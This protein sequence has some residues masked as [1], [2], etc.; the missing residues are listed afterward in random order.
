[1]QAREYRFGGYL[2]STKRSNLDLK[3]IHD[4][5]SLKSYWAQGRTMEAIKVSV[6]NSLCFGLFNAKGEQVGFARV[7]TDFVTFGWLCDVFIIETE[8]GKGLGKWLIKTVIDSPEL[9]SL[10]RIAL[11]TKDAQK[12]YQD[13]GGFT[14][15]REPEKWMER[16]R[17]KPKS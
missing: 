2:I 9:A 17:D 8:R 7:V 6:E 16:L 1:M 15:L 13:Y 14:G 11:G 10:K 5:L 4:Y 3:V 12:L